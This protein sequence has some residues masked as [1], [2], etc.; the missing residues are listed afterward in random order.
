MKLSCFGDLSL[1]N[2]CFT[3]S[4]GYWSSLFWRNRNDLKLFGPD[5]EVGVGTCLTAF[6][7]D[8]FACCGLT[9]TTL[10]LAR[11]YLLSS[12]LDLTL[13]WTQLA[14]ILGIFL[15]ST[16]GGLTMLSPLD[17]LVYP[18]DSLSLNLGVNWS[19]GDLMVS[20]WIDFNCSFVFE[21]RRNSTAGCL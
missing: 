6:F 14:P 7:S 12:I 1:N 4:L 20:F 19:Y 17:L 9:A 2:S 3:S 15:E 21:S 5:M 10:D 11:S 13:I 8:G 16:T 18:V